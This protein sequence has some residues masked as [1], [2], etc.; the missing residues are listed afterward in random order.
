MSASASRRPPRLAPFLEQLQSRLDELSR[1][2]LVERLLDHARTLKSDHRRAFLEIFLDGGG[3]QEREED[4]DLLADVDELTEKVRAGGFMQGWGWD[5]ALREERAWGDE[6]WAPW[7]DTLFN[8]AADA[9]TQGQL[10]L[11]AE[12]YRRLFETLELDEEQPRLP[13]ALDPLDMLGTDLEEAAARCLRAV[14]DSTPP[15]ERPAALLEGVRS[16][17]SWLDPDT[18]LLRAM[19]DARKEPLPDLEGFVPGWIGALERAAESGLS[20]FWEA[21]RRVL[22]REAVERA[23][24]RRGL[25]EL[26]RRTKDRDAYLEWAQSHAR[27]GD[28]QAALRALGEALDHLTDP[29][30][31]AGVADRLASLAA[32]AEQWEPA[33]SS[34]RLAWRLAPSRHRLRH[35]AGTALAAPGGEELLVD[36]VDEELR[37]LRGGSLVVDGGCAGLL[38]ILAGDFDAA[39]RR[40]A[41]A[42]TLGWSSEDNPAPDLLPFLLVAGSGRPRP[43]GG[44]LLGNAWEQIGGLSSHGYDD[45]SDHEEAEEWVAEAVGQ[46]PPEP[47]ALSALAAARLAGSIP[48]ESRRTRLLAACRE[49]ALRW[50]REI[51]GGKLRGAYDSAAATVVVCAEA[52]VLAGAPA[53]AADLLNGLRDEFPRHVAF[54]RALDEAEAG[55]ALL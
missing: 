14:Y 45:W 19:E 6:S 35:L 20:S 41:Q 5:P 36:L 37:E 27:E 53:A 25:A 17:G 8:R 2:Q 26:A 44:T 21:D 38:E 22:L 42:Q 4:S 54:Q 47:P 13:G 1:Q 24:G 10:G 7:M 46:P 49:V 39:E 16:V 23:G 30:E 34:R 3:R 9:F 32:L 31:R 40:L 12:A 29:R 28:L 52:L 15:A 50:V 43:P 18:G 55:S 33:L 51:V 11:A 48:D